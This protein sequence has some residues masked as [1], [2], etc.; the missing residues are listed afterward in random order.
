MPNEF[1]VFGVQKKKE[2]K[3]TPDKE[4]NRTPEN[5][6]DGREKSHST[7]E[8]GFSGVKWKNEKICSDNER[9]YILQIRK[10]TPQS[11]TRLERHGYT[12]TYDY[13]M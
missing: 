3:K 10:R 1:V 11:C 8:N 13:I 9:K 6:I 7:K 4:W 2:E 12:H 5:T